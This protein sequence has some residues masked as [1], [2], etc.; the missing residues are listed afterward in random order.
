MVKEDKA[1]PAPPKRGQSAYFLFLADQRAKIQKEHNGASCSVAEV[2][3]VAGERWREVDPKTKSKYQKLAE[4]DRKR[5]EEAKAKYIKKYGPIQKIKRRKKVVKP[6]N[7]KKKSRSLSPAS[8]SG[9]SSSANIIVRKGKKW[10]SMIHV[11]LVDKVN[12]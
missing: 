8:A 1:I 10:I 4:D 11:W 2:S 7:N 9:E 12:S 3:K 5:Y 6:T